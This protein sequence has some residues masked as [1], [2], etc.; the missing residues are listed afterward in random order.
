MYNMVGLEHIA[1]IEKLTQLEIIFN[2]FLFK[3][4]ISII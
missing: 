4:M 2:Q 1:M 3:S